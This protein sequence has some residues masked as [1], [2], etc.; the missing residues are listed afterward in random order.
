MAPGPGD[1]LRLGDAR[2]GSLLAEYRIEATARA[3]RDERCVPGG[4]SP[5]AATRRAQGLAA[6]ARIAMRAFASGSCT[7]RELAASIDHPNIIP[8]YE[9]GEADGQ[10]VHRDA[11][12][13]GHRPQGT[14][15]GAGSA[16]SLGARWRSSRRWPTRLDAAHERGLVHRD[17]KPSNVLLDPRGHCYL[18]DFGLTK[19]ISDRAGRERE[20]PGRRNRR[21]CGART[22]PEPAARRQSR[23]LLARVH[24]LRVPDG[25]GAIPARFRG[26]CDLCPTRGAAAQGQRAPPQLPAGVDSPLARAMAKLPADRYPCARDLV[27]AAQRAS[28]LHAVER[29]RSPAAMARGSGRRRRWPSQAWELAVHSGRRG[30]LG[31]S[32]KRRARPDRSEDERRR[33]RAARGAQA[34]AVAVGNGAVWVANHGDDSVSRLDIATGTTRTIPVKGTPIDIAAGGDVVNV[35][36]G[37]S[38]NSVVTIDGATGR[39]G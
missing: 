6:G 31:A 8:I 23:R 12:R 28:V 21:L 18:S 25:R 32:R 19:N 24:A 7:S 27:Q 13:R 33:R 15:A 17:V 35:V 36:N 5:A 26:R 9:A 37:P 16:A 38:N 1:R 29:C 2:I 4:G 14:A 30:R 34:T 22:D 10:P 11:L 20:R 39:T 3:R